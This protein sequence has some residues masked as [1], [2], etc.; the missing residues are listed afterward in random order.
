MNVIDAPTATPSAG[1][2]SEGSDPRQAALVASLR[3][4]Y[5]IAEQRQDAD[6][7][8]ALFKEAAYLGIRPDAYQGSSSAA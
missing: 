8:R 6:A 7:K 2:S 4:R 3:A 5:A 1:H